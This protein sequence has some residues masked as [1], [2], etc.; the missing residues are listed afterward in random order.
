M[1]REEEEKSGPGDLYVPGVQMGYFFVKHNARNAEHAIIISC[2]AL[3]NSVLND[4]DLILAPSALPRQCDNDVTPKHH[5]LPLPGSVEKSSIPRK[6]LPEPLLDKVR[7]GCS[8]EV[9]HCCYTGL[10]PCLK[11]R[12]D[13]LFVAAAPSKN[14]SSVG[15]TC[16]KESAAS[17]LNR[18]PLQGLFLGRPRFLQTGRPYGA[19]LWSRG[20]TRSPHHR[21]STPL[22]ANSGASC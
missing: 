22:V 14:K 18:S 9:G 16:S 21:Y 5:A 4:H 10:W 8:I 6:G 12:R 11:S 19:E 13:D 15:A 17:T 20:S 3:Q 1:N 2:K 7:H